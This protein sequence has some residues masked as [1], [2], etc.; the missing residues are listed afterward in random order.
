MPAQGG[1]VSFGIS[2]SLPLALGPHLGHRR[3]T[4]PVT[5]QTPPLED[6]PPSLLAAHAAFPRP[7][8]HSQWCL[9]SDSLLDQLRCLIDD[10]LFQRSCLVQLCLGRP[11]LPT[12]P[13][14]TLLPLLIFQAFLMNFSYL[15]ET[16]LRKLARQV[17]SVSLLPRDAE[18]SKSV[19]IPYSAFSERWL[20][21]CTGGANPTCR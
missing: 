21:P 8:S 19:V 3:Q 9:F 13:L 18:P 4:P 17:F 20:F 14:L 16:P 5:T 6:S 2:A 1:G 12:S 11:A 10:L 7:G 15:C